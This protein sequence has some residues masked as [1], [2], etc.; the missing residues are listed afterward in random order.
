MLHGEL[1][2]TLRI[3]ERTDKVGGEQVGRK[4]NTRKLS[5]YSLRE[6]CD[7]QCLSQAWH[8]LQQDVTVRQ[9]TDKQRVYEVLLTN[10]YTRNLLAQSVDKYRL[11]LNLRIELFDINYFVHFFIYVF[12]LSSSIWDC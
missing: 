10:D 4:L 5:I 6:C 3:D 8:T 1:L 7:S 11:L 12:V 9:K 2:V